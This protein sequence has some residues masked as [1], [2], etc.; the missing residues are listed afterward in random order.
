LEPGEVV[1][2]AD[3]TFLTVPDDSVPTL[4][5]DL[6]G[7]VKPGSI[8]VHTCGVAGLD[9]L[10]PM[11][12]AGAVPASIH[13][14]MTFTGS[15]LDVGRMRG[16]PFAVTAP[17][18]YLPIVKALVAELGGRAFAVDDPVRPAY[19]AALVQAANHSQVLV[20]S[21]REILRTAGVE[22]GGDLLRPLVEVALD[23]ALDRGIEAL[24][25]PVMRGDTETLSGHVA[26]LTALEERAEDGALA[27]VVDL[28]RAVALAALAGARRTGRIDTARYDS[29]HRAL[30]GQDQL[31]APL[32]SRPQLAQRVDQPLPPVVRDRTALSAALTQLKSPRTVVMTMGALHHGHLALVR[33]AVA[34][35]GSVVVTVFVNPLQF[36]PGEDFAAYPRTL[37]ADLR[38]L[39]GLGVDLV[40]APSASDMYP[41]GGT[42]MLIEPGPL[43]RIYEGAIR[44]GHFAGVLTVVAKLLARTGAEVAVFGR[45][46]AQQLALVRQMMRDLDCDVEIVAASTRR[47]PDGLAISSRNTYLSPA[48]RIQALVLP[49][50]IEAAALAADGGT[51][52]SMRQA[53]AA[54]FA[55]VPEVHVDYLDVVNEADFRPLD[56]DESGEALVIGACRVGTTRLID[57]AMVQIAPKQAL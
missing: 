1:A 57:N 17:A 4:A 41:T 21:A 52:A 26:A 39:A 32:A 55:A 7:V 31:P 37:E 38:A 25:G 13:P 3:I 9:V 33:E 44:P 2:R 14:V 56:P 30:T 34:Q 16:A 20:D 50:A 5:A 27:G 46:D 8:T 19:H 45:K 42:G 23:G 18:L 47:D 53:A 40:Y 35:G 48:E 12:A 11:R 54:I 10:E 24:T 6:A 15:S 36:G 29:A 22:S 43:G 51:P 28:Y 49:R